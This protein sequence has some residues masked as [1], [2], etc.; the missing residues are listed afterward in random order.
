MGKCENHDNWC[1]C[2]K[3]GCKGCFHN[4]GMN[5]DYI[6]SLFKETWKK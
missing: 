6:K 2:E 3:R 4:I 5:Y 1:E